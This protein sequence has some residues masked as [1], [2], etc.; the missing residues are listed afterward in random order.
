M[1]EFMPRSP[2]VASLGVVTEGSV[3]PGVGLA[4]LDDEKLLQ[5]SRDDTMRNTTGYAFKKAARQPSTIFLRI[6]RFFMAEISH[7]LVTRG[8]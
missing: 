5:G 6:I 7:T 1:Y 2:T 8:L 3:T 4:L